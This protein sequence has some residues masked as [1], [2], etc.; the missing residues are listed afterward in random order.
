MK[1]TENVVFI[2]FL[3]NSTGIGW[4]YGIYVS[5]ELCFSNVSDT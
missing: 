2:A 4:I 3:Y 1:G 5:M